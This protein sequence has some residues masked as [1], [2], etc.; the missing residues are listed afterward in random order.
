MPYL[1]SQLGASVLK[2]IP[3]ALGEGHV[4]IALREIGDPDDGVWLRLRRVHAG[5]LQWYLVLLVIVGGG[6]RGDAPYE[7]GHGVFRKVGACMSKFRGVV[8]LV[9]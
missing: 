5:T 9:R 3:I 6:A 1:Q 2:G 7:D 4:G 8:S